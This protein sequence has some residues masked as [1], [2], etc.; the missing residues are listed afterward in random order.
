MTGAR[1]QRSFGSLAAQRPE[2][3]S[4]RAVVD[5]DKPL[6]GEVH[7]T[8]PSSSGSDAIPSF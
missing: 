8:I 4:V 1:E 5:E 3:P 6:E 7:P 2:R